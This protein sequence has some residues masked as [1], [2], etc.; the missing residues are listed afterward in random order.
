MTHTYQIS[1][2]TCGKCVAKV[3]SEL[4]KLGDVTEADVQLN[5]PQAK[6][7]MQKHVPLNTLQQAIEKAGHYQIAEAAGAAQ[8]EEETRS[9]L[10]T[11][12]PVLLIAAYLL[13][14]TLLLQFA[15]HAFNAQQWMRH[16]MAGF[17]LV[18]S[19]FKFL[20]LRGFA[21]SYS[22]YDLIA[23]RWQ[24][25]G[26]VYAFTEIGL[27]IAYLLNLYPAVVNSITAVVMLVGLLGVLRAVFSKTVIQCACLGTVF[28]LPM[29]TITIVE[30]GAM[31]L[32]S[33]A[34][35]ILM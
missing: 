4:L 17:F 11:Y 21:E 22:S 6:I 12:K 16:F 29:S 32:M 9:W 18:F 33:V 35:L 7:S 23:K 27:G 20:D 5:A 31:L 3:K 30:D 15:N 10:T 2:M 14:I 13:G 26:F 8:R 24:G 34:M 1:G 28:N 25:W 19:F